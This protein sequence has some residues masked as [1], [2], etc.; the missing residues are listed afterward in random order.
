MQRAAANITKFTFGFC[1]LISIY[2]SSAGCN[3]ETET[4][5][6]S[7][8]LPPI[9][10]PPPPPP[11]PPSTPTFTIPLVYNYFNTYDRWISSTSDSSVL[12]A[13]TPTTV[14]VSSY[15]WRKISGPG[16]PLIDD[17][18]K[19]TTRVRNLQVG[20]YIFEVTA[21]NATGRSDKDSVRIYVINPTATGLVL[22]NFYWICPMG[23][24][25]QTVYKIYSLVP[26]N[27]PL[28]V[29]IKYVDS[30]NWLLVE[31]IGQTFDNDKIYWS[32]GTDGT[33]SLYTDNP[34]EGVKFDIKIE[35]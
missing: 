5:T 4:P 9:L 2:C 7:S 14:S 24:S 12:S 6:R 1:L 21:T 11:P 27:R 30:S 25:S 34:R 23:C 13:Y 3:K 18:T 15:R 32:V 19:L 29:S 8:S 26:E 33:F 10:P 17:S 28:H 22:K 31:P 35:F 20:D 16:N